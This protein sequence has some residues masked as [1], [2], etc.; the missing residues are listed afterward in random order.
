MSSRGKLSQVTY[1][2]VSS[3][4]LYVLTKYISGFIKIIKALL[5]DFDQLNLLDNFHL[6]YLHFP[7]FLEYLY[8][9]LYRNPIFC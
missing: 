1:V 6:S 2:D 9:V 7:R 4:K 3:E 8:R 5:N